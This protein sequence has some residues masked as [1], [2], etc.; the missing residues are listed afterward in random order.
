MIAPMLTVR[1]RLMLKA[2]EACWAL[3][4]DEG[5]YGWSDAMKLVARAIKA[6]TGRLPR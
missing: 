1:E 5:L 6:A 3:R 2:L 4:D